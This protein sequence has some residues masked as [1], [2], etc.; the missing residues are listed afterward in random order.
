AERA[1]NGSFEDWVNQF[2]HDWFGYPVPWAQ[3]GNAKAYNER[4]A[5]EETKRAETLQDAA[6]TEYAIAKGKLKEFFVSLWHEIKR[7][8]KECGVLYAVATTATD[9]AFFVGELA[10]GAGLTAGAIKLLKSI[11]FMTHISGVASGIGGAVAETAIVTKDTL[12]SVTAVM[13]APGSVMRRIIRTYKAGDLEAEVEEL[14]YHS[15]VLREDPQ[16]PL[17]DNDAPD[18]KKKT[19]AEKGKRAEAQARQR[20][21]GEGYRDIRELKNNSDNGID[22]VGR[23]P[24]TGAVKVVEVKANSASLNELQS[25]G[26]PKYA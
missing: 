13:G 5:R 11:K 19:N 16:K 23:N 20:L 26:G 1:K 25:E 15:G 14:Q 12:V 8:W 3:D 17:K 7:R 18:E 2:G 9:A 21:A 10:L 24:E 4:W 6:D 22:L